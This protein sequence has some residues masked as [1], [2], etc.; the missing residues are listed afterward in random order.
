[1]ARNKR[2]GEICFAFIM[3]KAGAY[4]PEDEVVDY[5]RGEIADYKISQHV[6]IVSEFPRTTTN[7]IQRFVL[8]K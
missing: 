5:C 1:M 2:L 3:P 7:K 4:T 8:Q 6:D